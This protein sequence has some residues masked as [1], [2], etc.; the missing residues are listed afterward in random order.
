MA[1]RLVTHCDSTDR[2][3][4]L[5][6][7]SLLQGHSL[8]SKPGSARLCR[9]R[10]IANCGAG[11]HEAQRRAGSRFTSGRVLPIRPI[12]C[13]IANPDSAA[14]QWCKRSERTAEPMDLAAT[15]VNFAF[16]ARVLLRKLL[17]GLATSA[18][19]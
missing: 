4:A 6:Y 3:R 12:A 17:A 1:V 16:E 14:R 19:A 15:A 10:A 5:V 8:R 2:P 7:P 11:G 18:M 9:G 13:S